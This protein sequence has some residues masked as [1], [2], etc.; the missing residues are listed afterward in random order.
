[1]RLKKFFLILLFTYITYSYHPLR[2]KEKCIFLYGGGY[3]GYWYTLSQLQKHYKNHRDRFICYSS[4]CTSF[5]FSLQNPNFSVAVVESDKIQ[6]QLVKSNSNLTDMRLRY[7]DAIINRKI[8]ISKYNLQ[9]LLTN[10]IGGCELFRPQNNSHL[11]KLLIETTFI[12][13]ITGDYN[14]TNDYYDGGMCFGKPQCQREVKIPTNYR[15]W[16]KTFSPLLNIEDK[17]YFLSLT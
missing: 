4:A 1:M 15:I 11:R 5:V 14:E 13:G 8:D 16:A 3:S 12:P 10:K 6:Q 9:I 2:D 7:I 17:E